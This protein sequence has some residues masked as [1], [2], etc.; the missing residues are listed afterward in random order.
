VTIEKRSVYNS[1]EEAV[2]MLGM[3]ATGTEIGVTEGHDRLLVGPP[4]ALQDR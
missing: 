4:E 2:S 1:Q 3:V